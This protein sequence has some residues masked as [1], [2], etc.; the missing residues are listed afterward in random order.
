MFL[1]LLCDVT[2]KRLQTID[3]LKTSRLTTDASSK[4]PVE[5]NND[6]RF[7]SS[8]EYRSVFCDPLIQLPPRR[9]QNGE[10]RSTGF[11]MRSNI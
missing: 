5:N 7:R 10:T 9:S 6:A 3:Y 11:L 1:E 4:S 8:F 2:Q